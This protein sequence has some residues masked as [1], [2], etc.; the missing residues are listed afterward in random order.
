MGQ[1]VL[2]STTAIII[3]T[4]H[5]G[6]NCLLLHAHNL[7]RQAEIWPYVQYGLHYKRVRYVVVLRKIRTRPDVLSNFYFVVVSRIQRIG[8]QPENTTLYGGQSRSWFAEQ[9]KN[10]KRKR[11]AAYPPHCSFGE[12]KNKKKSRDAFTGATRVS[13]GL[14]SVQGYPRLID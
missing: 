2:T 7:L 9:G 8:C 14:A 4:S 6:C 13:V 10:N 12:I 5:V 1:F 11:L 3:C